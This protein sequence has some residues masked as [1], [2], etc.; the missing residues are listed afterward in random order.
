MKP[1]ITVLACLIT[2]TSAVL[3]GAPESNRLTPEEAAE[4]VKTG[5]AVLI[6]VREPDEWSETGVVSTAYVLPLSDL[7]GGRVA[8]EAFL[9]ANADR[10]LILYCR[11]GNRSGQAM[12]LLQEEGYRTANAGGIG[13]WIDAGQPL[14]TMDEPRAEK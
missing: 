9:E 5:E 7:R 1:H 10:E 4:R 11:S 12:K 3:H 14:R 8:W 13:D 6:D 2:I